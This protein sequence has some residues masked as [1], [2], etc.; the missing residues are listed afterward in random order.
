MAQAIMPA[1]RRDLHIKDIVT[2]VSNRLSILDLE[3]ME[4]E[5]IGKRRGIR[6][7]LFKIF[8]QPMRG[9]FS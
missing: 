4:R 9:K 2:V 7:R 6:Q 5:R 1:I 3:C 8:L